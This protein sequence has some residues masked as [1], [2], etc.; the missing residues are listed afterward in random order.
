MNPDGG[1]S[2]LAGR[3]VDVQ[4]TSPSNHTGARAALTWR[5]E[6]RGLRLSE[7]L[8]CV[9]AIALQCDLRVEDGVQPEIQRGR[10]RGMRHVLA[11]TY[12]TLEWSGGRGRP[13]DDLVIIWLQDAC[14]PQHRT[15][16]ERQAGVGV[17]V[18][19]FSKAVSNEIGAVDAVGVG[20]L[21]G[22]L[23]VG[24]NSSQRKEKGSSE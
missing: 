23:R 9:R 8:L 15:M 20:S 22:Q 21:G 4:S 13:V 14:S 12:A 6:L 19:V 5:L 2:S 1:F 7:G 10:I 3:I 17:E 16:R 24:T 18:E 11:P